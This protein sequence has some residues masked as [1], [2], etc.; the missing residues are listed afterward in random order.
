M[1]HAVGRPGIGRHPAEEI[2]PG[3]D[4][5]GF[6]RHHPACARMCTRTMLLRKLLRTNG[7][8]VS[9]KHSRY[10]AV[11]GSCGDGSEEEK[12]PAYSFLAP[13]IDGLLRCAGGVGG[14]ISNARGECYFFAEQV[15]CPLRFLKIYILRIEEFNT[16]CFLL[17]RF[18]LWNI[19]PGIDDKFQQTTDYPSAPQKGARGRSELHSDSRMKIH[20]SRDAVA[21]R[22]GFQ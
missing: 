10:R 20:F 5:H 14:P 4:W 16:C 1:E 12:L 3:L 15:P 8:E 7:E 9:P 2:V 17:T 18:R 22:Q 13:G 21:L 19:L 11:Y 6:Q